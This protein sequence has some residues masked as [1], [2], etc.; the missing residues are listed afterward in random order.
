MEI[1]IYVPVDCKVKAID[2][3]SDS[4]F[5]N[6]MLGDG[7]LIEPKKIIFLPLLKLPLAQWYLKLNMRMALK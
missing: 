3:C 7:F 6:K 4:T 1:K 5:K 2:K